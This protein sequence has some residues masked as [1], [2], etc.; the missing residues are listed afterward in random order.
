MPDAVR[1]L[2]LLGVPL[3]A[4]AAGNGSEMNDLEFFRSLAETRSFTL[5]RPVSPTVTPDGAAVLFL[6][7]GP[8]DPVLRL[9]EMDVKSGMVTELVTP[10][11]LLGGGEELLPQQEKDRRERM[12][13]QSRGFTS[14]E[15]SRDGSSVLLTL[16]GRLFVLDR[17]RRKVTTLP[18]EAWIDPHFSPDAAWVAAVRDGDLFV[19][20]AA[21]KKEERVTFGGSETLT[22]GLAEFIAEEEMAR[23][24]GFWWSPD[25]K[26][27]MYEE[28]DTSGVDVLYIAQAL[29]PELPPRAMR[30]P[31][32]GTPNAKVRLGIV[33]RGG[34]PTTWVR[35]DQEKYPYLARVAWPRPPARATILV[36][37]RVQREQKL[38]AVDPKTGQ[39]EELF[40]E[41]DAAWLNLD[42]DNAVPAWDD[43]GEGFIWSTERGGDWQLELRD[44]S[45][46]LVRTLTPPGYGEADLVHV[47]ATS[48]VFAGGPDSR[49]VHLYTVPLDGKGEPRRITDGAGIHAGAYGRSGSVWVHTE[50]LLDGTWRARVIGPGVKVIAELPSVA[51]KP[52]AMPRIELCRAGGADRTFDAVILRP[53]DVEPGR[54]Y[55]VILS[56]YAGPGVKVVK[57]NALGYLRDQWMADQGFVVVS[58]DGRGT[59]GHGREWERAIKGNLIDVALEDQIAG[60]QAL[61]K[62]Y[63]ELDLDRVGVMG[64]S[65][66]GY[67]SAM[68]TLR[69]PDVFQ[70]RRGR[71]RA[72]HRLGRLRHPLHRALH[73]PA[74]GRT[75]TGTRP[76]ACSPTQASSS[77]RSSSST[78]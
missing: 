7:G 5:G 25:G 3:A 58:L 50:S 28:S 70:G 30:Y 53:H 56:V 37:D 33:G 18:G 10:E 23:H 49:E 55:P 36:Q 61:G 4:L 46:K 44:R 2:L 9:Y 24:R 15:L 47:D 64:W 29:H 1:Y 74:R 21:G 45:G 54:R 31:R 39:T 17:A 66:G 43:E 11:G 75:R 35:W 63:P 48:I 6:R 59:P 12:R 42:H 65:F 19:L 77:I 22:H 34:G 38:L 71:R 60:L 73:G 41:T 20:D 16:S 68:A 62:Q 72:G 40:T 8:R 78:G 67:F 76:R 32:P 51:E 14:Y 52:A 57:A 27:L 26:T 13:I 69:R